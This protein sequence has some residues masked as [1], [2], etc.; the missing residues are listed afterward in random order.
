M[1]YKKSKNKATAIK[2]TAKLDFTSMELAR[3]EV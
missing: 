2:I 1:G 3:L